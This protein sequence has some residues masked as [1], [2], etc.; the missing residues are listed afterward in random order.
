MNASFMNITCPGPLMM[1]AECTLA[2]LIRTGW[3]TLVSMAAYLRQARG[4][5]VDGRILALAPELREQLDKLRTDGVPEVAAWAARL[6]APLAEGGERNAMIEPLVSSSQWDVRLLALAISDLLEPAAHK[7]VATD[8][9]KD[10]DSAVQAMAQAELD[11]VNHPPAWWHWSQGD[12]SWAFTTGS[13]IAR[14][15]PDQLLEPDV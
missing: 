13:L 4:K 10:P 1:P 9:A 6:L 2:S 14:Y 7:R 3:S 5:N 12:R 11:L 15:G 8:L